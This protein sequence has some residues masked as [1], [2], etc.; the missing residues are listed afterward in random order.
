VR[1]FRRSD[2]SID[3]GLDSEVVRTHPRF[4]S[5]DLE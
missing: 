4:S 2:L 5:S 1:S 3:E